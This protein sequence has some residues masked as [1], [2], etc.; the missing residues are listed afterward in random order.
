MHQEISCARSVALVHTWGMASA[1]R[2]G[3]LNWTTIQFGDLLDLSAALV[4]IGLLALVYGDRSGVPRILLALSF[5]FFVPGRAILTNWPRM[6]QW[7]EAAMAPVLS[8][9]SLALIAAATLWAHLWH[10]AILLSIE[11]WIS[12]AGLGLGVARRHVPA[13]GG[14][15]TSQP[16]LVRRDE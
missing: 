14:R 3:I 11:A 9:A 7:S 16:A 8:L 4:A 5:A 12:I 13:L 2:A 6:A 10:P 15:A 1:Q